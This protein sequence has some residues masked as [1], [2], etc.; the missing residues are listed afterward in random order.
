MADNTRTHAAE[1]LRSHDRYVRFLAV[2][3]A[4]AAIVAGG[5]ALALRQ[6]GE[7]K[8]HEIT[9]L[10][11]QYTGNGAHTHNAD[12]YDAEGNLV[13]PLPERALHIH[14]ASCYTEERTLVCGQEETPGHTHT[15]ECYDEDGNLICGQ[16]E[17]PGHTHTDDCYEVTQ[18]LTCGQEEVTE[19]HV[20][21]PSCFTTITVPDDEE[22]AVAVAESTSLEQTITQELRRKDSDGNEYVYARASVVAPAGTLPTG[23]A[24]KVS[25]LP[26]DATK[27]ATDQVTTL[28]ARDLGVGTAIG[29]M[30]VVALELTDADGNKVAPTGTVEVK[31]S[32]AT[33]READELVLVKLPNADLG[34][35]EPAIVDGVSLVNWDDAD[36][37][38][39]NE[40]TLMFW[41]NEQLCS[42]AIVEVDTT[43][44]EGDPDVTAASDGTEEGTTPSGLIEITL[45]ED[46]GEGEAAEAAVTYPEQSFEA[47]AGNV[48]VTVKAPQGAFPAG[49][50]MKATPVDTKEA[51][52]AVSSTMPGI[53]DDVAAVDIVFFDAD[54][55]EVQPLVP[56]NVTM[57]NT[58][59]TAQGQPVVVHVD[60][61]GETSVVTQSNITTS[62]DEVVFNAN[63]F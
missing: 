50:T 31:V 28:I 7:A 16:E 4:I 35:T 61:E 34:T 42:Y 1:L 36:T 39:G 8:V 56:I 15:D 25:E 29:R 2:L 19:E 63:E 23:A 47:T 17:T 13:C 22:E 3:A 21:G 49:T 10:D 52:E 38:V 6:R 57:T 32:T 58:K 9:V 12:C 37:S 53:F 20:H 55:T 60:N 24:L 44:A 59:A 33:V 62:N 26:A 51:A 40:D 45:G 43:T 14:D 27:T 30:D 41:T 5:T 11:C 46:E 18:T 48:H 54:G